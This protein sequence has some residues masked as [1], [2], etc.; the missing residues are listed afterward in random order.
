MTLREAL[1]FGRNYLEKHKINDSQLDAWYLL[2]YV[3]KQN[4]SYFFLHEKE[5]LSDSQEKRYRDY[6]ETRGKH[7]PL[8]YIT[9][10]QEFMG[11][12]F[13]VNEDVLIPR[14]DTEIL[15]EEAQKRLKKDGAVLD[16]CTG[17][18]CIIISLKYGNNTI[19]AYASD[20]S[21]K[22]IQ[23]A[24]E[25]AKRNHADVTLIE[26]NLFQGINR[27][28]D[29]I[30]SNPPYIPTKVIEGLMQEVQEHEPMLAL[31]GMDDGLY[32]YQ[33]ISKEAMQYLNP[34]GFLC[35]EIGHD[36]A[37]AVTLL[38]KENNFQNVTIIK[39]LAGLDR[40]IIGET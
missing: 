39:D 15:V 30:V 8:Q 9:K 32:F 4:R 14:Q 20:V 28:F 5:E 25:N 36:Q 1:E 23:V 12:T 11:L 19:H 37:E 35:F 10:E 13:M 29:M 31:D 2:E 24:Q 17:S 26:S 38:M 27:K 7:I 21:P 18:G 16:L 3:I 34:G 6:I 22:A 40:V 33:R